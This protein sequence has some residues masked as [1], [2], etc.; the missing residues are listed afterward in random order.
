MPNKKELTEAE[1][2]A[3]ALSKKQEEYDRKARRVAQKQSFKDR[4]HRIKFP[5]YTKN[6]VFFIILVCLIDLQLTYL[7]AFLDHPATAEELSKHLCTTILG[8]A[9]TYMVRAYFDS[10]AEHNNADAKFA[11]ELVKMAK[12]KSAAIISEISSNIGIDIPMPFDNNDDEEDQP[13][14]EEAPPEEEPQPKKRKK[15]KED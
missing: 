10:R 1:K 4:L 13:P 14:V 7:L 2:E 12:G 11:K 5:T 6:L 8:V 9:F 3:L 15:S